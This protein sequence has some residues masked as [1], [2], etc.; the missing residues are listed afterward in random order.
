MKKN[1]LNIFVI[2][3]LFQLSLSGQIDWMGNFDINKH[4]FTSDSI[5]ISIDILKE[6][7]D[8]ISEMNCKIQF[9]SS[10]Y[11]L[12]ENE[13]QDILEFDLNFNKKNED[14]SL[15]YSI[16]IPYSLF[17][18]HRYSL[19]I[20][21][22][23]NN[24]QD[25]STNK[26]FNI[27]LEP[28]SI[29]EFGFVQGFSDLLINDEK[30]KFAF[31]D[32][33]NNLDINP[34][35]LEG[36]YSEGFCSDE[37]VSFEN[38]NFHIWKPKSITNFKLIAY[39][40]I[41]DEFENELSDSK[42]SNTSTTGDFDYNNKNYNYS[43]YQNENIEDA[44]ISLNNKIIDLIQGLY[45][46]DDINH[47]ISFRFELIN[48]NYK[49]SFPT[50]GSL[51]YNIKVSNSPTGAECQAALLPIDLLKWD[52]IKRE[53]TVI[54]EWTTASE[55]NNDYFEIQKSSDSKNWI[56][57]AT[58]EG[59]GTTNSY[60]NYS[61]I[62]KYPYPGQN[63][64]RLRQSDFDGNFKY[65]HVKSI[66]IF[67]NKLKLYPNPTKDYIYYTLADLNKEFNVEIYSSQ[68]KLVKKFKLP[69]KNQEV[70]RIDIRNLRKGVYLIKYIDQKNHRVRV[71]RFVKM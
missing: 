25:Y 67:D 59:S 15:N 24:W 23:D 13:T 64:Y 21:C 54:F 37:L 66:F 51:T 5:D 70:D 41:D 40:S 16:S 28:I 38:I 1:V 71:D 52:A 27:E 7:L 6:K 3:F 26:D 33:K 57:L 42:V 9:V 68:G 31:L 10:K 34:S 17:S 39:Y 14:N 29:G 4:V 32:F 56:S 47:K 18:N 50:E 36:I 22:S 35:K 62:D 65:S 45:L 30:V 61:S 46:N 55:L 60:H 44:T 11:F 8:S 20:K 69:L 2:L 53:K 19:T 58:I 48:G 49:Y 43:F 12:N 63:Y